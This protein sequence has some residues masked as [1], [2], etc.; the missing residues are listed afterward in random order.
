M[1]LLF[2]L[3]GRGS[4]FCCIE[5]RK[6]WNGL[7]RA[8]GVINFVDEGVVPSRNLAPLFILSFQRGAIIHEL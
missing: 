6:R 7:E 4:H 8:I 1:K 3:K 5:D 2:I